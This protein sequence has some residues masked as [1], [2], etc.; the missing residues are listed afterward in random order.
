[1]TT[2]INRHEWYP[3]EAPRHTSD[4]SM[5]ESVVALIVN[6]VRD[7]IAKGG[8]RA[9]PKPGSGSKLQDF[10]IAAA[11]ERW[12]ARK[13]GDKSPTAVEQAASYW[14]SHGHRNEFKAIYSRFLN[15]ERLD[16]SDTAPEVVTLGSGSSAFNSRL[17]IRLSEGLP[18]ATALSKAAEDLLA[19][20]SNPQSVVRR[21]RYLQAYGG[22]PTN[23]EFEVMLE[24]LPEVVILVKHGIA[25][26]VS[27]DAPIVYEPP[28]PIDH[29][30]VPASG[31]AYGCG[32]PAC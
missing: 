21:A 23:S 17:A 4:N 29:S 19:A 22:N 16:S 10:A 27:T 20:G 5:Y 25:A 11:Q 7:E 8:W 15:S 1:M 6:E 2:E 26:F 28:A 18:S 9:C 32:W 14:A 3:K 30:K 13:L 12:N 24:Q 31:S